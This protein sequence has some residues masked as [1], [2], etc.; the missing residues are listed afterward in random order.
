MTA[1]FILYVED[2]ARSAAFY[3]RALGREPR[4]DV[5]GMTEFELDTGAVLGLMP[6]R[7]IRALLGPALPDP[8]LARGLPRAEL[9]LTVGDP[10][11]HHR[12]AIE[13]G[14]REL[15]APAR[16]DWGDVA[17]Y[18]L[19]P[20]GHVL[21][22]AAPAQNPAHVPPVP[23]M[24][25][26]VIYSSQASAEMSVTELERILVDA[27]AGNEARGI[28]GALVYVDGVFLQILEGRK[29][30]V[31]ELMRNIERDSR[32]ASVTVFD[33]SEVDV[34]SFS[35]WRMAYL[36]ATPE[37]LAIW[38]G[39]AGTATLDEILAD[40]RERPDGAAAVAAGILEALAR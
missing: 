2:Q 27:R 7:G 37:Q 15:S 25:Y 38:A 12:R 18:L 40:L 34:P 22:F 19:D 1:H 31:L 29:E 33:E 10:A 16:R 11:A 6:E 28:T 39:L 3:R 14:A 23:A 36:S 30:R 32:H 20:D 26:R 9:Y 5:P 4:L 35:S 13:A 21:A 24:T 8:A 17:G